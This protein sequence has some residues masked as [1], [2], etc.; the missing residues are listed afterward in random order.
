MNLLEDAQSWPKFQKSS[1]LKIQHRLMDKL[2]LC[3]RCPSVPTIHFNKILFSLHT[4]N[5]EI[6]GN[7]MVV[8]HV[9][10]GLCMVLHEE[11]LK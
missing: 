5:F 3:P 2:P 6:S 4:A 1:T 10:Y 11:T 8:G 7:T 9:D